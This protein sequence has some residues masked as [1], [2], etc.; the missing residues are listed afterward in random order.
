MI[1]LARMLLALCLASSITMASAEP[2]DRARL[3]AA[4]RFVV[5]L[6][7]ADLFIAGIKLGYADQARK[8]PEKAN[9]M[10]WILEKF[11]VDST[12]DRLT[13]IYAKHLTTS[14]FNELNSFYQTTLGQKI[15]QVYSKAAVTRLP[16][17][18]PQLTPEETRKV[19]S[20]VNGSKALHALN[21]AEAAINKD[22]ESL[23]KSWAQEILLDNLGNARHQL[24]D[25]LD[26]EGS[27]G[28]NS[29]AAPPIGPM[30]EFVTIL[31]TFY[32]QNLK[33]TNQLQIDIEAI[34]ASTLLKPANLTSRQG[35][36]EGRNKID[37]YEAL[38]ARRW[39][40]Y[41]AI[42]DQL[43]QSLK[44]IRIDQKTRENLLAGVEKGLSGAYERALRSQENQRNLVAIFRDILTL[45]DEKFGKIKAEENRLIFDSNA[46]LQT[47]ELLF[48]RLK[49]EAAIETK[50]TEEE[51]QV[52]ENGLRMLRGEKSENPG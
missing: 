12:I 14:Q 18:L 19:N 27:K 8:D 22:L 46:D 34:D 43:T 44:N 9:E 41:N 24:A 33:S 47:Y 38:L 3:E 5:T 45:A 32:E 30:A 16:P 2:V 15:W 40:E 1:R 37:R 11:T 35:I 31:R 39:R 42:T 36:A 29:D 49:K 50:I 21:A 17:V 7:I 28:K 48:E 6:G 23:A 20:F 10:R 4:R 26:P 51:Q 52:R 25:V 13:P